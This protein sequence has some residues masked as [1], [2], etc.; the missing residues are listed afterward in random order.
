M[1]DRILKGEKPADLPVQSA[2][3]ALRS[4]PLPANVIALASRKSRQEGKSHEAAGVRH[5]A[6]RYG[7]RVAAR[8]ARAAAG[9]AGARIPVEPVASEIAERLRA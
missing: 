1:D 4:P 5:S 8:G 3:A 6:R 7:C 9:D 2:R